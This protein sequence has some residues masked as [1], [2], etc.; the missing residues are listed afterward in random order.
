[1]SC[2]NY[3]H[4]YNFPHSSVYLDPKH[5]QCMNCVKEFNAINAVEVHNFIERN[6]GFAKDVTDIWNSLVKEQKNTDETPNVSN[7]KI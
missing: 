4:N 1:M 7:E 3:N 5:C 2:P 6:P